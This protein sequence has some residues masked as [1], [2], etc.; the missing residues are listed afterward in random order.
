MYN[1]NLCANVLKISSY[2]KYF[3]SL[4]FLN[5]IYIIHCNKYL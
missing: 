1:T 5:W 4:K 3:I 2:L